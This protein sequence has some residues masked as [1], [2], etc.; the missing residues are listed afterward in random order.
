VKR[1]A[2]AP[3]KQPR[4]ERAQVTHDA[5]LE[6]GARVLEEMGLKKA[7]TN[8]I[9]EVAGVSI[10]SLYQ[11]FPNK[12]ALVEALFQRE[13]DRMMSATFVRA[14]TLANAEPML[15]IRGILDGLIG[16]FRQRLPLFRVLLDELPRVSGLEPSH[17][18]DVRAAAQLRP[19]LELVRS[20][21]TVQDLDAAA[22]LVVRTVRYNTIAWI[23]DQAFDDLGER[24]VDELA[25]MLFK[26]LCAAPTADT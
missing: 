16:A 14:E 25:I 23:R 12:E 1:K 13:S 9:A 10:G 11:F 17:R 18:V 21:L 15:L 22:L 24:L 4:Q 26:Y 8:R 2:T 6:A 20:R 3:R 5:I 19:L 7:T